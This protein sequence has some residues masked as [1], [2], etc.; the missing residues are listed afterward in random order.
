[1]VKVNISGLNRLINQEF[2]QAYRLIVSRLEEE[3]FEVADV[4][5]AFEGVVAQNVELNKVKNKLAKHDLTRIITSLKE[6]RHEHLVSLKG[7]VTYSMKS[8]SNDEREAAII[9]N[10]WL[11]REHD[12]LTRKSIQFQSQSV[13]RMNDD[14]V[15]YPNL[16]EALTTLGLGDVI[17]SLVSISNQID[18]NFLKRN[19]DKK[20]ES[21]K[22]Y[23]LRRNAYKAMQ[24]LITSMEQV[25]ELE[26]D[27]VDV[28][29]GYL[30][31][32]EGILSNFFAEQ[33]NRTTRRNNAAQKLEEEQDDQDGGDVEPMGGKPAMAGGS[34]TLDAMALG[35][36]DLQ[37]GT[38]NGSLKEKAA[39]NGSVTNGAATNGAATNGESKKMYDPATGS[40]GLGV[41]DISLD[42]PKDATKKHD[43]AA[44]DDSGQNRGMNNLDS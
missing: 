42:T 4:Q 38:T 18:K 40:G 6:T 14:V 12:F 25:I 44:K 15:L 27:D 13:Y 5:K 28:Y 9:L 1:M 2:P 3:E 29:N 19:T 22:A 11:D 41:N 39:M 16:F 37:N 34:R 32:I 23:E 36:M 35:G 30:S 43:S 10:A 33:A 20:A 8:H 21:K 24:I 7:R 17:D 26:K 31:E